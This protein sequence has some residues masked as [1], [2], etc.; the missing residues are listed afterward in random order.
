[1]WGTRAQKTECQVDPEDRRLLLLFMI[2]PSFA[3]SRRASGPVVWRESLGWAV[4]F[5]L[6]DKEEKALLLQP[7]D[8]SPSHPSS[9][10]VSAYCL[11]SLKPRKCLS[12]EKS[13]AR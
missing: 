7:E 4:S 12:R 8:A 1:M 2:L 9:F 13:E 10:S 5:F 3:F 11:Q 6:F